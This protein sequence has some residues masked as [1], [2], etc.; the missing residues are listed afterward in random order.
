MSESLAILHAIGDAIGLLGAKTADRAQKALTLVEGESYTYQKLVLDTLGFYNDALGAFG[1]V[2]AAA[3]TVVPT[4]PITV[5]K[6]K[7]TAT[8]TLALG[9]PTGTVVTASAL[10]APSK[11]P[12]P[13]ANVKPSVTSSGDLQVDLSGLNAVP[14]DKGFYA[15]KVSAAGTVIAIIQLQVT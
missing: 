1:S 6:G 15:G 10:V 4:L 8:G 7:D 2:F 14:V 12:V 5:A 11:K 13:A 9:L 3:S